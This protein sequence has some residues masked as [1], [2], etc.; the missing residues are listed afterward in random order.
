MTTSKTVKAVRAFGGSNTFGVNVEVALS[1]TGVWFQRAYAFNGYAKAWTK[2][3]AFEPVWSTTVTNAY[4]G[5][6]EQREEPALQYG[7][8]VLSEY[9]DVPR[10]RLPA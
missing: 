9:Q 2:W 7:W 1:A 5:E 4:T 8:S 6:T 10:Y 3:Q